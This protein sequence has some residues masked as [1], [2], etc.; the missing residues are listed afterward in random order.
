MRSGCR[1][2]SPH[3]HHPYK[4]V[5]QKVRW[6]VLS[7]ARIGVQSVIPA[8]QAGAS[9]DVAAIASRSLPRAEAAADALGLPKAYGSYEALLADADLDAVYIS[10]PNH[11]HVPWSL[12][13]LD[14][15]KHVLCEKPVALDAA[16]AET[17]LEASRAHP[18]LKV[19]EAFM[20]RFHPQWQRVRALIAEGRLG[21]LRTVQAFFSYFNA[22]A[23]DIRNSPEM[24]GGALMDIGCYCLSAA[25][26]LFDAEP[27]RVQA[28]VQDDPRFGVDRLTSGVLAFA[29]GSGAEGTATFTCSAQLSRHQRV[30]V[31]GTEGRLDIDAP[32]GPSPDEACHLRLEREG[33]TED[34]V[35]KPCNQYTEQGERFSKAVLEDTPVP[36]PLDDAVAN[37]RAID[38]V[39]RSGAPA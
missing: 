37:M 36:T 24:G 28:V 7:T 31:F 19:M 17:L 1:L 14:A 30:T 29:E 6:G 26:W 22:D 3:H 16:E 33:E 12:K 32:F 38:A 20:Y 18:H 2:R 23:D 35:L 21:D 11:L 39:R 8:M 4:N 10:L 25:R 9:C 13:A 15:G 34:L 5:M 27:T